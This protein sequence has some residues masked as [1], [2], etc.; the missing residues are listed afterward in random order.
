MVG[1]QVLAGTCGTGS[2]G[3]RKG[4][5]SRP[6]G[7][8]LEDSVGCPDALVEQSSCVGKGRSMSQ[9]WVQICCFLAE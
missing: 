9:T 6:M 2:L 5:V 3:P 4:W 1:H 8:S 7:A